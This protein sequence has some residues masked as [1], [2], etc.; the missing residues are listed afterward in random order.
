MKRFV[1]GFFVVALLALVLASQAWAPASRGSIQQAALVLKKLDLSQPPS[2][3]NEF[4]TPQ[5]APGEKGGR[6]KLTD[7][8]SDALR[9]MADP[10][11][12]GGVWCPSINDILLI[13][14]G[15]NTYFDISQ[16]S[17]PALED[18]KKDW[19]KVQKQ[20]EC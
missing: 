2:Y 6:E 13:A 17:N 19:L 20:A 18:F 1:R 16:P 3:P 15:T 14:L 5:P 10:Q 8:V 9:I 4:F 12:T 7:D 11:A